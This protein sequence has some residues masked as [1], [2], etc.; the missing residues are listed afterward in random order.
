M[1]QIPFQA[2][3]A[4]LADSPVYIERNSDLIAKRHLHQMDYITLIDPRQQGKTSLINRLTRHFQ[5]CGYHFVYVDLM[6]L[7]RKSDPAWYK[8]LCHALILD[9]PYDE[10]H[11]PRNLPTSGNS[12]FNFLIKLASC[13]ANACCN[14]VIV[15]DE[16]G[17]IPGSCAT[18]FF[19]AIRSVYNARQPKP[20]FRKLTFI[21]AGAHDPREFIKDHVVSNFNIAHCIALPDF[22]VKQ[23][24]QLISHFGLR[25]ELLPLARQLHHWTGGQP[26]ISQRICY[27]LFEQDRTPTPRTI[28][29][30]VDWF[31]REDSNHIKYIISLLREDPVLLDYAKRIIAEPPKFAPGVDERHFRLSRVIGFIGCGKGK[32][33]GI[34][35]RIYQK[36][37]V[38]ILEKPIVNPYVPVSEAYEQL[39][40]R[41]QIE[42]IDDCEL[43]IR[44]LDTPMG[45]CKARAKLPFST[46]DLGAVLKVLDQGYYGYFTRRQTKSLIKLKLWRNSRLV[47]GYLRL[48]G[49]NIYKTLF[50]SE[51]G[52]AFQMTVNQS[53]SG[54]PRRTIALQLRFSEEAS[55]LAQYPW[56]LAHDGRRHLLPGGIVDLTRYITYSEPTMAMPVAPPWHLLYIESRPAGSRLGSMEKLGVWNN[57][58][59]LNTASALGLQQLAPPTYDK[60]T[61][62]LSSNKFQIIH[63]DGHGVFARRCPECREIN[64]ASKLKCKNCGSHLDSVPQGYLVF[65]DSTAGTDYVSAEE[66][67]NLFVDSTVKLAYLSACNSGTVRGQSVFEGLGPSLIRSGIPAVIAMQFSLKMEDAVAFACEFY[68]ALARGETVPRAVSCGRRKLF[69]SQAWFIPTLYL[70]S[71]DSTGRLFK[72]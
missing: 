23:T 68:K 8:S 11:N 64:S 61:E 67:E 18:G 24:E 45:E 59:P 14:L 4:L 54:N 33:C 58:Q 62:Q 28:N 10:L 22:D 63:F 20:Y 43:E 34:R 19:S 25:D 56:E 7:D 51:V 32:T 46:E 17:A 39:C 69:R 53:R 6:T 21:V 13:A 9:M 47:N 37:I 36:A 38:P 41:V 29:A 55:I 15:L 2:G 31:C 66:M 48:I 44:A 71:N 30:A 42:Q 52:N 50:P 49:E 27:Y 5:G 70:R 40:F 16:V 35:N 26:Y 3:G 1:N 12:W 57:L 65:Q 72:K 60:F